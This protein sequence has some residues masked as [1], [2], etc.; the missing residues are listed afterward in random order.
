MADRVLRKKDRFNYKVFS[1]KG[2]KVPISDFSNSLLCGTINMSSEAKVTGELSGLLFEIEETLEDLQDVNPLSLEELRRNL[3][4]LKVL[5]VSV[6]KVSSELRILKG[7]N[8]EPTTV[9]TQLTDLL[10]SSKAMVGTLKAA[11]KGEQTSIDHQN[12]NLEQRKNDQDAAERRARKFAF[13]KM[14]TEIS[15]LTG[16]LNEKYD[17]EHDQNISREVI[18]MRKEMKSSYAAEFDRVKTLFD[19]IL[20]YTDVQ[21]EDKEMLLNAHLEENAKL[22]QSSQT[23]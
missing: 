12:L 17:I 15:S 4:E 19:R 14:L 2:V 18:L 1:E 9:D 7:D 6:V 8:A 20:E 11:I 10:N 21:F 23:S 16:S 22:G 5:R 3:A 13:D